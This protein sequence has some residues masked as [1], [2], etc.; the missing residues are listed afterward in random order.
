MCSGV[1]PDFRGIVGTAGLYLDLC[2]KDCRTKA[3]RPPKTPGGTEQWMT[4]VVDTQAQPIL[5]HPT[6]SLRTRVSLEG[7]QHAHLNE[8]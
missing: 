2:D 5:S 1:P 8:Q 7:R 3:S 4:P 6:S